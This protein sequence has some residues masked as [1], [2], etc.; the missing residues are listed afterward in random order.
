MKYVFRAEILGRAFKAESDDDDALALV[1]TSF[2]AFP[3][4]P[5]IAVWTAKIKIEGNSVT[6]WR[7]GAG[8]FRFKSLSREARARVAKSMAS[9]II[10]ASAST[11]YDLPHGCALEAGGRAVLIIGGSGSGKTTLLRALAEK[12]LIPLCEGQAPIG[13]EDG[14]IR[15]F[16]R[17]FETVAKTTE[18][19]AL[20]AL[21]RETIPFG[22]AL[23]ADAKYEIGAAIFLQSLFPGRETQSV[24]IG[25]NPKDARR[26]AEICASLG[27]E[28]AEIETC[29]DLAAA[30]ARFEPRE[31]FGVNEF[32]AALLRECPQPVYVHFSA[33]KKP[34]FGL[35]LKVEPIGRAAGALALAANSFEPYGTE[36]GKNTTPAMAR[37][38]NALKTAKA[39][40]FENGSVDE[41]VEAVFKII[42]TR[43]NEKC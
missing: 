5:Q 29:G 8:E 33:Y 26:T 9:A 14:L 34:I 20:R 18:D 15:P 38:L 27:A 43:M 22:A 23:D 2:A 42:E 35:P 32:Q 12:G 40:R 30:R 11:D 7:S 28:N 16:P 36:R 4:P 19:R 21:S 10:L 24:E 1:K 17:G 39:Y 31:G 13:R 37:F 6:A 41:R 25:I 3:K